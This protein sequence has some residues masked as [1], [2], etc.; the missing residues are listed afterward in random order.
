MKIELDPRS[1]ALGGLIVLFLGAA[2]PMAIRSDGIQFTDGTVQTTASVTRTFYLTEQAHLGSTAA[3]ACDT[4]Y[5]FASLWEIHD[6]SNLRYRS[7][8]GVV[9]ADSGDGP[10]SSA[11]GWIRTGFIGYSNDHPGKANCDVWK[12]F[13][14]E[15]FGSVVHLESTWDGTAAASEISPWG[16]GTF[17]CFNEFP[18]WCVSD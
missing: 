4:G 10:P 15:E 11:V 9:Q 16:G 7:S 18:V 17:A 5:H 13:S 8:G 12:S 14:E 3:G 6:V 2:V 1:L